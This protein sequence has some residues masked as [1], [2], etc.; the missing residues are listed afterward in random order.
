MTNKQRSWFG[1][2]A[3][4]LFHCFLFGGIAYALRS[5][6]TANGY[7]ADLIDTSISMEMLQGMMVEPEPAPVPEP[8]PEVK[9]EPQPVA[10]EDVP[11]PTQQPEKVTEVKKEKPK[12][13]K[14]PKEKSNKAIKNKDLSKGDRNVDSAAK[15]DSVATGLSKATVDNPN[16]VGKG[17]STDEVKAYLLALRREFERQKR[18]PQRAKL[19]RKQGIVKISFSVANNGTIGNIKVAQSSGNADLDNAALNAVKNAQSVGPKPLGLQE[20]NVVP[21][22]FTL[23]N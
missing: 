11:D 17:N 15:I 20:I 21:I 4:L 9:P 5:D 10:K 8:E 1:F 12:E 18:Y 19:M 7:Q 3:S 23:S 14:K 22:R 16:L 13:K 6:D 2:L